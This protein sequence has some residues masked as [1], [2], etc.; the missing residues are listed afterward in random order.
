M[1]KVVNLGAVVLEDD[2]ARAMWWLPLFCAKRLIP[3]PERTHP[4]A[5]ELGRKE[6]D[7]SV[8]AVWNR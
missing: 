1:A 3:W 7:P 8:E 2:A 4:P 5:G 6:G